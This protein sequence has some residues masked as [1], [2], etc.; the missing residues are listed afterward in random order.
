[1]VQIEVTPVV[2]V[3]VYSD[4]ILIGAGFHLVKMSTLILLV[5]VAIYRRQ[6]VYLV[7]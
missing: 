5:N 3:L 6:P 7:A 2:S 1:M 4:C